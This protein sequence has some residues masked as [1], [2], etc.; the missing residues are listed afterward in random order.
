MQLHELSL[1]NFKGI[2][3]LSIDFDGDMNIYGGNGTG[4]TTL[5]DAFTWLLFGKDSLGSAQFE[6]KPLSEVGQPEHGLEH[7]VSATLDMDGERLELRKVLTEKWTKPRGSAERIFSGHEVA[8]FIDSV[9]VKEREYKDRIAAIAPEQTFRL[10]T[11]PRYFSEGMKW[12]DRRRIL[13]DV[14]G[15]ITDKDVIA[16]SQDLARLPDILGK[17]TLENYRLILAGR[18]REINGVLSDIPVRISEQKSAIVDVNA[19]PVE[20]ATSLDRLRQERSGKEAELVRIQSGGEVAEKTKAL[21]E[22]EG[23]LL[24]L[25]NKEREAA[26]AGLSGKRAEL[27]RLRND[28]MNTTSQIDQNAATITRNTEKITG[29]QAELTKLRTEYATI[30]AETFTFEQ[31]QTCP[32]CGQ[33]LPEVQIEAAR[34]KALA[35]FNQGKA[36][37]LSD[38]VSEGKMRKTF[39]ERL[40]GENGRL[41]AANAE[42][43]TKSEG[44][45]TQV[46]KLE[47]ELSTPAPAI[48]ED[49][50][51][52]KLLEGKA[53]LEAAISEL[54][55]GNHDAIAEVQEQITALQG[56]IAE[57][58]A[59]MALTNGNKRALTRIEEL[60]VQERT[61]A[62]ELEK[63]E[64]ELFLTEQFVRAKVSMLEEKINS[65]FK[66]AR[67]K[68]FDQQV[69][70]GLAE[71]CETTVNGVP[72]SSL[73][74]AMRINSG[75]D[76]AN[77]LSDHY[78]IRLP[79]FL[80]N[81]ESINEV[82]SSNSQQIRL[83]VTLDKTMRM[84]GTKANE[85]RNA[86]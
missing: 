6:I 13:L 28:L 57:K 61:L 17:H 35:T 84:E 41:E 48:V 3:E 20:L 52:A 44:L 79:M 25:A 40:T 11:N 78:G 59:V 74:N 22:L 47:G 21:R 26:D 2:T 33:D 75:I 1:K 67:F 30:N 7:E 86:A 46:E 55:Q 5:M 62:A 68:L 29:Y 76:I 43:R 71:C 49:P 34:S 53:L 69:N 10:L 15:D 18:R 56:Q 80:D 8:H 4:K 73:N 31:S 32:T 65:R 82:L 60:K 42:I 9:P 51:R 36:K 45:K 12:Q 16:S 39:I 37:R 72:Y 50:E 85:H 63:L 14:C 83:Y 38:N 81:M 23:K 19:D 24:D 58:E 66:I 77:T 64:G 27:N 70:G 54:R